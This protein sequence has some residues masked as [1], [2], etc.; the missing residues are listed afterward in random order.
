MWIII[1][2][3]SN[4][5]RSVVMKTVFAKLLPIVKQTLQ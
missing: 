5:Y 2:D 4:Y 1:D 3:E